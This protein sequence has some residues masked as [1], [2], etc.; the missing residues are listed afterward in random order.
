MVER[1]NYSFYMAS[2]FNEKL[3]KIQANDSRLSTLS[4]SQALYIIISDLADKI[5]AE[6]SEHINQEET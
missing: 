2:N 1:K 4:K 6:S 5:D 3:S